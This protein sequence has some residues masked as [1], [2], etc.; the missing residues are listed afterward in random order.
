MLLTQYLS[1]LN[2]N[3]AVIEAFG[4]L[5]AWPKLSF[6]AFRADFCEVC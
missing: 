2:K 3:G 4:G 5:L 6:Y 1:A